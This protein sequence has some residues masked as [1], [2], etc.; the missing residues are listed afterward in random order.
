MLP[1]IFSI[2]V[3]HHKTFEE[4]DGVWQLKMEATASV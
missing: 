2:L 4:Q 3:R 1:H